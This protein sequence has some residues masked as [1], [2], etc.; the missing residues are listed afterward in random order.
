MTME[1]RERMPFM[2]M[3][4]TALLV[5]ALAACG[6][7]SAREAGAE[8]GATATPERSERIGSDAPKWAFSYSGALTGEISGGVTVVHVVTT[9]MNRV[10]MTARTPGSPAQFSGSYQFPPDHDPLGEKRML[11]FNLVLAD[12]TRCQM[13]AGQ[14]EVVH[15]QV[16]DGSQ[17]SYHA[18]FSGT[19]SCG[20]EGPVN[21]T[22]HF[23]N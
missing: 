1:T 11:S 5:A 15:A 9:G 12:G 16:I 17:G 4:A 19:L 8:P 22:G 6:G 2:K 3:G 18:E 13:R 7:D 20:E 10:T 23:R 21:V 14:D